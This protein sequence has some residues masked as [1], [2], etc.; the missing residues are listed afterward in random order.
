MLKYSANGTTF[1]PD[2]RSPY[3]GPLYTNTSVSQS[4]TSSSNAVNY[5]YGNQYTPTTYASQSVN[6]GQIDTSWTQN[7]SVGPNG[8][9]VPI[10]LSTGAYATATD[11]P[12]YSTTNYTVPRI[13][14]NGWN[15]GEQ[16]DNAHSFTGLPNATT[17]TYYTTQ[18]SPYR[19]SVYTQSAGVACATRTVRQYGYIAVQSGWAQSYNGSGVSKANSSAY[20]GA[21]Y[22]GYYDGTHGTQRSMVG[23]NWG[24][25]VPGSAVVYQSQ[26][27]LHNASWYYTTAD[28]NPGTGC[29]SI[30]ASNYHTWAVPGNIAGVGNTELVHQ[31]FASR[32]THLTGIQLGGLA[33]QVPGQSN[34][35]LYLV[36]P[37]YQTDRRYYGQ[38]YG[39][40]TLEIWYYWDS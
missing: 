9:M 20:P 21:V 5:L 3:T 15:G 32:G 33:G 16:T 17:Y 13:W 11:G 28:G 4:V 38:S 12:S 6:A 2:D 18:R 37:N 26:I 29:V 31:W 36:S 7:T 1:K 24:Y 27:D 8:S 14:E 22:H 34:I 40:F 25:A 35:A 10:R 30:G 39:N 23:F 19:T